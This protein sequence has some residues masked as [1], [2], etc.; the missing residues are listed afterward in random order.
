M[1]NKE[2]AESLKELVKLYSDSTWNY[3]R[4][5][6]QIQDEDLRKDLV[7]LHD[8]HLEHMDNLNNYIKQLGEIIPQYEYTGEM[9]TELT[10]ITND[11]SDEEIINSLRKNEKVLSEKLEN[12]V[13]DIQ[14]P[15]IAHD[16]E[17]DIDDEN[18]YIDTL[19]DYLD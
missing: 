7:E 15:E 2:I 11:M 4:A 14:I 1:T 5:L 6:D 8:E 17:E 19:K 10:T 16:L 3:E 12:I 13:E 18:I 9:S